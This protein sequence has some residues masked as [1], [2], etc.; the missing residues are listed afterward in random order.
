[1]TDIPSH[2]FVVHA[3]WHCA[4]NWDSLKLY[5]NRFPS[6][7]RNYCTTSAFCLPSVQG[8]FHIVY[9]GVF[10]EWVVSSFKTQETHWSHQKKLSNLWE[11]TLS[12]KELRTLNASACSLDLPPVFITATWARDT[13]SQLKQCLLCS[14]LLI[15]QLP[16]PPGIKPT[17]LY[18]SIKLIPRLTQMLDGWCKTDPSTKKLLVDYDVPAYLC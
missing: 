7:H 15:R 8:Y 9:K 4:S 1:M 5:N 12:Y 6:S 14:Q 3:K 2:S 17:K 11:W 18:G 13:K 16:W 10:N